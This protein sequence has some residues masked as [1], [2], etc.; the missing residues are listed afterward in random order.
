MGRRTGWGIDWVHEIFIP[1]RVHHPLEPKWKM[2]RTGWGNQ[3][4]A[5]CTEYTL[6]YINSLR[7]SV[8]LTRQFCVL[9]HR[10]NCRVRRPLLFLWQNWPGP[11]RRTDGRLDGCLDG[12]PDKQTD[13]FAFFLYGRTNGRICVFLFFL[14]FFVGFFPPSLKLTKMKKQNKN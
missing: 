11:D 9:I 7:P 8:R 10:Q 2:R 3:R 13:V 5:L 1:K 12:C 6:V 4:G 14:D